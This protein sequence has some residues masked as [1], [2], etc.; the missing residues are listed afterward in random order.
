VIEIDGLQD[1]VTQSFLNSA[2]GSVTLVDSR[3]NPDPVLND[4][5]MSYVPASNGDYEAI[6]PDTFDAPLGSGYTLEI[7]AQQGS[8]QSF[9]SIPVQVKLRAQ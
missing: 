6:V 3:G 2:S 1:L 5:V 7:T 4:I 9:W 8:V